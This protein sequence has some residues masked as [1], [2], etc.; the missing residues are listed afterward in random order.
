MRHLAALSLLLAGS[1]ILPAETINGTSIKPPFSA[2]R[3]RSTQIEYHGGPILLGSVP[4]YIIY[5]GAI[6]SGTQSIVNDFFSNLGGSGQYNVNT[7]YYDGDGNRIMNALTFSPT[8]SVYNDNYSI[9]KIVTGSGVQKIVQSALL[10]GHLPVDEG[11][12][13]FV[14]TSPDVHA[15]GFCNSFCA[16]HSNSTSIISGKDIKYSLVPDPSQ[17]C[18]GCSG[19]VAVFGENITPNGDLGADEMTD[20]IMHELSETVSDPD[21]N[22]WYTRSGA[23]NGDLC[24]FN[25]GTTYIAPNGSHANA[26]LGNRDYLIQ[27]IWQNTGKGFCANTLP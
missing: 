25:Y 11:G 9:G 18:D 8:T 26:H 10:N 22:A 14:I 7:T 1:A 3:P 27:T 4:V 2:A 19:N 12:V 21:L 13:Y 6:P 24:N 15:I 20:S 5:Y 17:A 23:E 16:Y